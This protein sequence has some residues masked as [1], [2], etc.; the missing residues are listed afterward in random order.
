MAEAFTAEVHII[1]V[2]EVS[3]ALPASGM[4]YE[5][6]G[7]PELLPTSAL[8]GRVLEQLPE[9]TPADGPQEVKL[10]NWQK[11]LART[12]LKSST[13]EATGRVI[14]EICKRAR[15]VKADLIVMGRHGHGAMYNLLVGGVTEG[16]LK[17]SKCPVLL[18]PDPRS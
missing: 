5:T 15:T 17:H 6:L 4:G 1:Q 3:S 11:E 13:H 8:A 12:G 18:V 2:R 16:V 14:D 9:T 7:V 10:K